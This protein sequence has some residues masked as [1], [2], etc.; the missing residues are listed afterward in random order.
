VVPRLSSLLKYF[1]VE[2]VDELI[3][4]RNR[5]KI[6]EPDE[7]ALLQRVIEAKANE[8]ESVLCAMKS[9][10]DGQAP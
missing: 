10:G 7:A 3:S 4:L 2:N 6:V 1:L 9:E 5:H 8:D